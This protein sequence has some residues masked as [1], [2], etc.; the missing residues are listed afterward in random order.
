MGPTPYDHSTNL[1]EP[2]PAQMLSIYPNACEAY[3]FYK[4]PARPTLLS[5]PIFPYLSVP[6]P[7]PNCRQDESQE[8]KPYDR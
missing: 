4:L 2:C 7:L 8:R 3:R 5:F 6:L 1:L